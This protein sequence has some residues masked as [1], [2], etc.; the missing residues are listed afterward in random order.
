MYNVL[1]SCRAAT[2]GGE[3]LAGSSNGFLLVN[4]NT[5]SGF[6]SA[7]ADTLRGSTFNAPEQWSNSANQPV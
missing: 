5:T 1:F 4:G 2:L 6:C 7:S 3:A